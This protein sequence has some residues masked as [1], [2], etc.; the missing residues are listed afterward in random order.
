MAA[1]SSTTFTIKYNPAAAG[2]STA[3]ISFT[4]N[5]PTT[6]SPFTFAV[7]GV[8]SSNASLSGTAYDNI[9]GQPPLAG[10][11]IQL[12]GTGSGGS[13]IPAQTAVTS[14]TG[15]YSFTKLVAG[16]YTLTATFPTNLAGG[17]GVV[18]NTVSGGSASGLTISGIDLTA[19][20]DESGYNFT[21]SGIAA[22][23][24]SIDLFLAS[25]PSVTELFTEFPM[26]S[27][28]PASQSVA[29]GSSAT[30]PFTVSDSLV[31]VSNV[32]VTGTATNSASPSLV[33][34]LS[35]QQ[36][37]PGNW[38]LTATPAAG[39]TGSATITTTATDPFGN[40]EQVAFTLS[41]TASSQSGSPAV[42]QNSVMQSPASNGQS[43]ASSSG[44]TAATDAMFG[45]VGASSSSSTQS[46]AVDA[47]LSGEDQWA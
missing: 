26:I 25:T 22:Q 32:A 36:G 44:S 45:Q 33:P 46:S 20:A 23:F 3:T 12:T 8:A 29:S 1:G 28:L 7:S 31:P 34:T 10:I 21:A 14:S 11:S 15:A 35:Y 18:D 37:T 47:A 6:T 43:S 5:D 17:A 27:G 19:G 24:F 2:T 38:T 41:V 16:T 42:V 4:E 30:I 39:E 40:V 9:S 13:T